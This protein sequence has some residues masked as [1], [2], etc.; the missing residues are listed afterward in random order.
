M[1]ADGAAC[2]L[3]SIDSRPKALEDC[4]FEAQFALLER[5]QQAVNSVKR[6]NC[7]R[8]ATN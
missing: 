7:F 8:R 2:Q 6:R 3:L 4:A 5:N 1:R